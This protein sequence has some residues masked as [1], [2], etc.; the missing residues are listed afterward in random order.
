MIRYFHINGRLAVFVLA[1][2]TLASC[3]VA[4]QQ[5]ADKAA[6]DAN[7][8][9]RAE[10]NE[11]GQVTVTATW[12][13]VAAGPVFIVVM[14][15]HVVDL[16]SYDLSQLATLR[17]NDGL[18]LRPSS[19]NSPAGEHHRTGTLA[20]PASSP[21]GQPLIAADTRSIELVIRDVAGVSERSFRW[22]P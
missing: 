5:Q 14:N 2:L 18:P 17:V 8:G 9:G 12:Q 10:A 6:G 11:G 13:G 3:G 15:T 1:I 22:T 16:D 21:Q 4:N 20:F 19:W 7:A